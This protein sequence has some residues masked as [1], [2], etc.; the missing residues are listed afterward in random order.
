MLIYTLWWLNPSEKIPLYHLNLVGIGTPYA[1]SLTS[2][3][4]RLAEAH[5]VY[6]GVMMEREIAPLV[7]KSYAGANLHRIYRYTSTL[8][9][10]GVMASD[11]VR[12]LS[13]LTA[14][15]QLHLLTL[16]SWS[17]VLPSRALMRPARA[18]CPKCY[19]D[20]RINYFKV[21][22][23]LL[24][25]L[26]IVQI[27]PIHQQLLSDTC[28]HCNQ[29]SYQLS[30]RSRSGHCS[31]CGEWLGYQLPPFP[32]IDN[33]SQVEVDW[34]IWAANAV[35][36]LI[37]ATP[38]LPFKISRSN[39]ATSLT[40]C[41][42][43]FTDDNIAEF[44][45][46]VQTPKNTVWLWCNGKNLPQLDAIA[47]LCFWLKISLLDLFTQNQI[48]IA[49]PSIR[50]LSTNYFQTKH[51]ADIKLTNLT[52]V[53]L[54]L[55]VVLLDHKL[56]PLSLEATARALEYD[57]RTLYRNFKDLCHAIS[58]KYAQYERFRYLNS[59]EKCC[60]EIRQI[61]LQLHNQGIYPS[62]VHV[63]QYL[64]KPGYL[65]NKRVR[66]VLQETRKLLS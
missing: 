32:E 20:Q 41:V 53:E 50:F 19:E 39:V 15:H 29:S 62:E 66:T 23:P 17:E 65:R 51:R 12:A 59:I 13:T 36:E 1:E 5:S 4:T 3:I 35:G 25:T 55:E 57:R 34:L 31:K 64:T 48:E 42:K 11:L 44:A 16:L 6:P 26:N 58:A 37:A 54:Q 2:H 9:S 10:M 27:C 45:R 28:P 14:H 22:E 21:Y 63:S 33:L 61:V 18:W 30:W 43:L 7:G 52:Q 47:K 8:N 56:P 40:A 49:N 38:K 24:W 60:E 46:L